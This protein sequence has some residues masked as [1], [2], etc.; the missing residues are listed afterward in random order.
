MPESGRE[1]KVWATEAP[2]N[3]LECP[4]IFLHLAVF[5]LPALAIRRTVQGGRGIVT[6]GEAPIRRG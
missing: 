1:I 3:S 6:L 5:G 2:R 4:A